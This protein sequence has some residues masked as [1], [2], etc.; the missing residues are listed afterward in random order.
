MTPTHAVSVSFDD[1]LLTFNRVVGVVRRRNLPTEGISVGPGNGVGVLRLS[2]L[3]QTDDAG[4]ERMLRQLEKTN[5]VRAS[6]V[7]PAALALAREVALIKV[8][9][10][11]TDGAAMRSVVSRFGGKV[12]EEGVDAVVVEVGGDRDTTP[13]LLEALEPFG[14]I[15][16][17]R[18][19]AVTLRSASRN[20]VITH[21]SEAVL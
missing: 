8:R 7:F 15:E 6:A 14:I 13:R 5:G 19:G 21:P 16:V 10:A 2:V 1:D 9:A 4:A 3:I 11:P 12:V 18:S 17:A 20:A